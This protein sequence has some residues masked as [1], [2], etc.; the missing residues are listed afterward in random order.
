MLKLKNLIQKY[1]IKLHYLIGYNFHESS[2][3]NLLYTIRLRNK[4]SNI[5]YKNFDRKNNIIIFESIEFI[6]LNNSGNLEINKR[7]L[8]VILK[9]KWSSFG[10]KFENESYFSIDNNEEIKIT[11]WGIKDNN[12]ITGYLKF[13]KE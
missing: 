3:N 2:D 13:I 7:N 5:I 8:Y 10:I 4:D 1:R 9:E 11:V 12:Y 6:K